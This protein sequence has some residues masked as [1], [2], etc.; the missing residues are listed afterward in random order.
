[1]MEAAHG[2]PV[3]LERIHHVDGS[4]RR[5]VAV[6][7]A[8]DTRPGT[9]DPAQRT[10]IPPP[11]GREQSR[12][13]GTRSFGGRSIPLDDAQLGQEASQGLTCGLGG[14]VKDRT[15]ALSTT[16]PLTRRSSLILIFV[17]RA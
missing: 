2:V 8:V 14:T 1:M 7:I 12:G 17:L 3:L 13:G 16:R 9:R 10:G 11:R 5:V 15:R 6:P 4:G